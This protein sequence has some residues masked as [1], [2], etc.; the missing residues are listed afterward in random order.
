MA[1]AIFKIH[2]LNPTTSFEI[3]IHKVDGMSDTYRL[4]EYLGSS[5]L[6]P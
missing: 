3:F 2:E 4:G 6:S 1:G 5:L